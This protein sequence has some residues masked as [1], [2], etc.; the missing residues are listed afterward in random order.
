MKKV[1]LQIA[2]IIVLENI[3]S[4]DSLPLGKT[5]TFHNLI[6]LIMSVV[7]KNKKEYYYTIFLEKGSYKD[8]WHLN[9]L[10]ANYYF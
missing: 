10:L 3:D 7:N 1:V 9:Q 2:I 4:I 8:K 6:I 5:L